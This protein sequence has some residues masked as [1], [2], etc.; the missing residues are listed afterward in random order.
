MH[1]CLS[2]ARRFAGLIDA[3]ILEE[4]PEQPL[5]GP[6]CLMLP[7]V[8]QTQARSKTGEKTARKDEEKMSAASTCETIPVLGVVSLLHNW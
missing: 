5:Y 7:V 4:L 3:F 6:G 1:A 8:T 2:L